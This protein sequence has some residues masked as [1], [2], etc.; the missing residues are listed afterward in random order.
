MYIVQAQVST[1]EN[2]TT[3]LEVLW[4]ATFIQGHSKLD[5]VMPG[6]PHDFNKM[7]CCKQASDA[8][9]NL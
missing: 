2:V 9:S 7:R 6:L 1:D 4:I 3:L 8:I 5:H